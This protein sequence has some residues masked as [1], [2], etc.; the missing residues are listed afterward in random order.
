MLLL[1][2]A[3]QGPLLTKLTDIVANYPVA[4]RPGTDASAG[5]LFF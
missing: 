4:A 1:R 3:E 2:P 5:D